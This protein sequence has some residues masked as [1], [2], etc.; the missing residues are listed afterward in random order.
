[1][2]SAELYQ[3]TTGSGNT[4]LQRPKAFLLRIIAINNICKSITG[5]IESVTEVVAALHIWLMSRLIV[6]LFDQVL[7]PI[8]QLIV[9]LLLFNPVLDPISQLIVPLLLLYPVLAGQYL[10]C[11]RIN[12][13]TL[14]EE[15]GPL[16]AYLQ[17]VRSIFWS[18]GRKRNDGAKF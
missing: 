10:N 14:S 12:I 11:P 3:V 9:S 2:L 8:S 5:L 15:F 16:G 6:P 1:M 4:E 18:V 7:D 17:S 13:W